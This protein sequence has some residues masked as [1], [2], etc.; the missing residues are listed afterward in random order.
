MQC[1]KRPVLAARFERGSRPKTS[2]A[3]SQEAEQRES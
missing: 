1:L 2:D 3:T